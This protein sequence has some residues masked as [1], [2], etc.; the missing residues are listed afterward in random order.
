MAAPKTLSTKLAAQLPA[1]IGSVVEH[2]DSYR[3]E[4]LTLLDRARARLT[5]IEAKPPADSVA[6]ASAALE[7][8]HLA[9]KA[10]LA[11]KA[12]RSLGTRASL[13]LLPVLY[14]DEA[15][16]PRPFTDVQ[17]VKVQGAQAIAAAKSFVEAVGKLL[18]G[19]A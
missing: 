4:A 8:L 9:L 6:A 19:Q 12:A 17:N 1:W 7:P 5:E 3:F 11:A 15:P 13:E 14:A 18:A 10:L 2:N 16:D